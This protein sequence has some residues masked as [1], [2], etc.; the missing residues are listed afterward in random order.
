MGHVYNVESFVV[1]RDATYTPTPPSPSG[2]DANT[3]NGLLS[4][5]SLL[6]DGINSTYINPVQT[7]NGIP[8]IETL[9]LASGV[10]GI[11][12]CLTLTIL[13]STSTEY[14]RRSF[15][16]LFWYA[17]QSTALVFIILFCVHGI[18]GAVR[19]QT[20]TG[21]NDPQQCYLVYTTWSRTNRQCDLPQ[22]SGS[23]PSS[24]AWMVLS[25]IIYSAERFVRFVRGRL[26]ERHLVKFHVHP[27]NVIELRFD[28][29][30]EM[31]NRI[32]Y[33]AGQY[34]YLNARRIALLEWHPFTI[35]SSP[36]DSYLS[37]HVRCAGDW[38][39][40]LSKKLA[41][42]ASSDEMPRNLLTIDGPY[43]S[44]AEDIFRYDEVVLIGAGIGVT[45]YASILKDIWFK[46]GGDAQ[47]GSPSL[48]KLKKVHFFW[49]CSTIDSFEWFGVLLQEL[50]A[51]ISRGA[52]ENENARSFLDIN[53]Y[54]T[55]GWSLREAKQ[56]AVNDEQAYDLFTG[57][58]QKTNY[59]RPN[60]D[61]VL[62]GLAAE[63]GKKGEIGV[64]FCGP[65]QL[66]RELHLICNKYSNE[67]VKLVY[68]KE[69]F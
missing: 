35:T 36:S 61:L 32:V 22:F 25:L 37:V 16:N 10:T 52:G 69:S 66:S 11:V 62:R 57:L 67:S 13:I 54:L 14:M 8:I 15:Y 59:G 17:H 21:K 9:K 65:A 28:N 2:N 49:I 43:G 24:W 50:E 29:S 5:L 20:N 55:R 42:L 38:T 4:T 58:R 26:I 30:L 33:R 1:A 39:S 68:N 47:N 23:M 34:V 41:S 56:I 44:C 60:F 19:F 46:L 31:K 6:S 12:M 51:K 53:I 7:D 48:L 18:Q 40:E 27:S 45:P 3:L 64:F 63:E